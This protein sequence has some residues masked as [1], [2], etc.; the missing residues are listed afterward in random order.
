MIVW[1]CS[2]VPSSDIEDTSDLYVTG[3]IGET[4][5]KTDIHYRSQDGAV[6]KLIKRLY[7]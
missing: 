4:I 2:D 7:K 6:Y 3:R 5:Q 1:D